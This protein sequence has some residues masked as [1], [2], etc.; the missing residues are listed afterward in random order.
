MRVSAFNWVSPPTPAGRC[1][2][3][4]FLAGSA[5]LIADADAGL[6][7]AGEGLAAL[8][9][10][11]RAA[12]ASRGYAGEHDEAALVE[13]LARWEDAQ[14]R[15]MIGARLTQDTDLAAVER[16]VAI[17]LAGRTAASLML[18]V[19]APLPPALL[20]ALAGRLRSW[21]DRGVPLGLSAAPEALTALMPAIAARLFERIIIPAELAAG[22][23]AAAF[24]A[25]LDGPVDR[26]VYQ[27]FSVT[28]ELAIDERS[29]EKLP[30]I[31]NELILRGWPI[32]SNFNGRL[33]PAE[34]AGCR[35]GRCHPNGHELARRVLAAF[36]NAPQCQFFGLDGWAG[37]AAVHALI[38]QGRLPR[39]GLRF[40]SAG[41]GLVVIESDG[42]HRS[43]PRTDENLSGSLGDACRNCRFLLACG[44][45]CRALAGADGQPNCPPFEGL[46]AAAAEAWLPELEAKAAHCARFARKVP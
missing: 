27:R 28:L 44:G 17:A 20:E 33:V 3:L 18:I 13:R 29:V 1:L 2:L 12:L 32:Q 38:W 30:T 6:F 46:L 24:A 26:L 7:T 42:H 36:V 15:E 37:L 41:A 23:T 31:A 14:R 21:H 8:P 25:R 22:E 34:G 19:D 5:D 10:E 43:C 9:A 11:E 40:C 39:P 16:A 45:G 35:F 4:N